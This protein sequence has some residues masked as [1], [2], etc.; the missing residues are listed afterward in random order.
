MKP[1]LETSFEW[2]SE[3]TG[4]KPVKGLGGDLFMMEIAPAIA[5]LNEAITKVV[6]AEPTVDPRSCFKTI[7]ELP[8]GGV[9][10]VVENFFPE[11]LGFLGALPGHGKTF[12]GLSLTKALTT[13]RAFL[14]QFKVPNVVPVLYLIPETSGRPFK[15]RCKKF[16]IPDDENLFLCRTIS[17]GP[18][19]SLASAEVS[20]IVTKLKCV[21]IID[22]AIR[23][24]NADDENSARQQLDLWREMSALRIAGA[25]LVIALHHS[26]KSSKNEPMSQENVLRGSGEIA[27]Q[28]D[29][30]W[31]IRRDDALFANGEGPNEISVQCV[32]PRDFEP[33]EP[34]RCGLTYKASDG[35]L[36]SYLDEIGDFLILNKIQVAGDL[37]GRFVK[38]VKD[39]PQASIVD[40]VEML[41][42]KRWKILNIAKKLQWSKKRGGDWMQSSLI[43]KIVED[44]KPVVK[45][46]KKED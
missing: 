22:T 9:T 32:K 26:I 44:P 39:F 25:P 40:L 28:A 15:G 35:T 16:G 21:V 7:G 8:D 20:A 34:F 38:A 30:I 23:F 24:S 41:G 10:W 46:D 18:I 14:G 12:M 43:V 2:P 17:E 31:G 36:H 27:A 5:K 33:P 37:E 11:G 1:V 6:S 4:R 29:A 13:G 19:L 42:D 45:L 3:I